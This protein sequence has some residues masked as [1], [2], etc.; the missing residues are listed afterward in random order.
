M[1]HPFHSAMASQFEAFVL[2]RKAAR[3]WSNV[4]DDNLHFFDNYCADHYPGQD[5]LCEGMLEWCKERPTE[6][7]NSCKYRIS[8]IIG[9]VKYAN[10]EG[11]TS[12]APPTTPSERPCLYIPHAFTDEELSRF[13]VECDKHVLASRKHNN[14]L[15]TRLNQLELPV[16]FRLLFS[17]GMRTHEARHLKRTDVDLIDG[18]IEI[19]ETK[20]YDQHRVALHSSLVGLLKRYDECMALIMPCRQ[21]FFPDADD[22]PHRPHWAE[23]HFRQ[24]WTK[25]SNVP[26]RPYDIRS[27]YA[28]ANITGWKGLG[29]GIHD[30][31]LYLSRTMGH[32]TLSSTCWYFNLSPGLADKIRQCSEE[33]F[34]SLLPKI[35]DYEDESE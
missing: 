13:F 35:E 32:R 20:G 3:R 33:S 28:V 1:K 18:I 11:W 2:S 6:H 21:M 9:F 34:N 24:I 30:K 19:N 10:K 4:Y 27:H 5:T 25:I 7:G 16:Y 15:Y 22:G 23:Y 31:L 26:A 12:I 17:T 8:A 29:Y 14:T